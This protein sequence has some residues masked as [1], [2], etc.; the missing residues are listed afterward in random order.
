MF[1]PSFVIQFLV[2]FLVLR[3]FCSGRERTAC[4]TSIVPLPHFRVVFSLLCP[5]L[6]VTWVGLKFLIVVFPG[7]TRFLA[8]NWLYHK[9]TCRNATEFGTAAHATCAYS[10]NKLTAYF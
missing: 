5:F 7:H 1:G 2:S 4:N 9:K 10:I 3:S 6:A 8:L